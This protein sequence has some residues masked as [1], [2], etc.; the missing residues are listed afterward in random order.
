MADQLVDWLVYWLL[1]PP[2][3]PPP[4][5][6]THRAGKIPPGLMVAVRQFSIVTAI[7][8]AALA[9]L[10][11]Y[12]LEAVI[13]PNG[14]P[15]LKVMWLVWFGVLARFGVWVWVLG[16]GGGGGVCV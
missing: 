2:P 9:A 8:T 16:G 12:E 1:N 5:K 6:N 7:E 13:P 3:P 4:K 14:I 11:P 15:E 10:E